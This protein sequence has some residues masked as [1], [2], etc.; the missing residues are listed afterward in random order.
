MKNVE[1]KV[2][3]N[4]LVITADLTQDFGP[5][6]TGKSKTVA[7]T[8]GFVPLTEVQGKSVSFSLNVISK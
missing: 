2:D 5:T 1:Y 8:G 6:S 3:G 4:K 7:S